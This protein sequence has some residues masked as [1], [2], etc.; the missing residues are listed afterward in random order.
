MATAFGRW[1]RADAAAALLRELTE[2]GTWTYVPSAQLIGAAEAAGHHDL[3][4]TYVGRAWAAREP[5]FILL[6][7]HFPEWREVR[8]DPRFQ[9]ILREMDAPMA[10]QR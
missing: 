8:A 6:A 5:Q 3:A 4:V 2:R 7:R 9:A 1:G 10:E